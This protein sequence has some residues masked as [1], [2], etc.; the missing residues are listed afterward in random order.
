MLIVGVTGSIG[1]G[2]STVAN[3]LK[4]HGAAVWNADNIVHQILGPDGSAVDHIAEYFGKKILV[5]TLGKNRVNRDLLGQIVFNNPEELKVLESIIHPL[6]R[7]EERKFLMISKF[8][9]YSISVLDIPLLFETHGDSRCD[10]TIVATAPKFVQKA[11]VLSR[12]GMTKEKLDGILS[13][14]MSDDEKMRRADFIVRTGLDKA[15]S[16]RALGLIIKKLKAWPC[17]NWPSSWSPNITS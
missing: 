3:V 14:Q 17:K 4:K 5:G 10:A 16:Y 11:R 7:F 2:K 13:R 9:G 12:P 1:M 6:I 8:N 15:V